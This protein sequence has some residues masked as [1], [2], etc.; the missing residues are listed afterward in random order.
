MT[1]SKIIIYIYIHSGGARHGNWNEILVSVDFD[2]KIFD[3]G[4]IFFIQNFEDFSSNFF[5][6]FFY[7]N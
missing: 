5:S 2:K 3:F 7:L 6:D 4:I 1:F